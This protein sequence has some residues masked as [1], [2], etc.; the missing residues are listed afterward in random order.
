MM[1]YDTIQYHTILY[2]LFF[3]EIH[4]SLDSSIPE[5]HKLDVQYRTNSLEHM[6]SK[7]QH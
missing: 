7:E 2:G 4:V 3:T 1:Q 6:N 5:T